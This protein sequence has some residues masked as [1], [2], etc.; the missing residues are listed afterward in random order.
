MSG[1]EQPELHQLV[2]FDVGGDDHVELLERWSFAAN[3]SSTTHWRK[4]SVTTGHRSM[5][6]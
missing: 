5:M 3:L 2:G 4:G 1:V 6:P